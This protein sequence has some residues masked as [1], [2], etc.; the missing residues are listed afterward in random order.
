MS[1][2]ELEVRNEA[3]S[4]EMAWVRS[5]GNE[6]PGRNSNCQFYDCQRTVNYHPRL[7]VHT[8][9]GV[10]FPGRILG[11]CGKGKAGVNAWLE[12]Y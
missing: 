8:K 2:G 7:C 3:G 1:R 6:K 4:H 5:I 12:C 10:S 11:R 9:G